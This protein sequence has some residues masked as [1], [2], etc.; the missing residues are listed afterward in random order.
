VEAGRHN[1]QGTDRTA[2]GYENPFAEQRSGAVD[3]VQYNRER[4]RKG[5]FVD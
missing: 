5:S 2:S 3:G 4:L 1:R